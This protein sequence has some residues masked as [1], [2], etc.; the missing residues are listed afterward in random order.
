MTERGGIEAQ[1]KAFCAPK[2]KK[3][4][5]K[6]EIWHGNVIVLVINVCSG[7]VCFDGGLDFQEWTGKGLRN[8]YY[9]HPL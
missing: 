9:I 1:S 6:E 3:R 5:E 2:E 4:K 8:S 7:R